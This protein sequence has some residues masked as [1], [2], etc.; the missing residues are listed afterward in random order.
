[1]LLLIIISISKWIITLIVLQCLSNDILSSIKGSKSLLWSLMYLT[2]SLLC[3]IC[4][5][6]SPSIWSPKARNKQFLE[7]K[8]NKMLLIALYGSG[9]RNRENTYLKKL[10]A[11][12]IFTSQSLWR[13]ERELPS[14]YLGKCHTSITNVHLW[15]NFCFYCYNSP[16]PCTC[17]KRYENAERKTHFLGTNSDVWLKLVNSWLNFRLSSL[18][19]WFI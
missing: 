11:W 17:N 14:T 10:R 18:L 7:K 5:V 6:W 16:C 2:V 9:K 3:R 12:E 19:T 8:T 4:D 15:I 13:G 1:M